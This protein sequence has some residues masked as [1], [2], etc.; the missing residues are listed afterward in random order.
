M[1]VLIVTAVGLLF[2]AG[3]LLLFRYQCQLRIDRQHELEKV[4]AVRSALNYM[5]SE[6]VTDTGQEFVYRNENSGRDLRL[7]VYPSK[8]FFPLTN[9]VQHVKDMEARHFVMDWGDFD[10][11]NADRQNQYDSRLD[12]GYGAVGVEVD[13]LTNTIKGI[14]GSTRGLI[15]DSR[16]ATND[17]VRCWVNI[18]MRKTGGWL[19]EEY[20]RRYAFYPKRVGPNDVVRLWLIRAPEGA[21]DAS[22]GCGFGWP[23]PSD[24]HPLMFE[25]KNRKDMS[26]YE[27]DGD[28]PRNKPLC[29]AS[30]VGEMNFGIQLAHDKASVFYIE[31]KASDA[32]ADDPFLRGYT[33]SSVATMSESTYKYFSDGSERNDEG[34]IISAPDMRVVFEV[35]L[36]RGGENVELQHFKVTPGYQYEV[37][38]EHPKGVINRATVAQRMG[39][40]ARGKVTLYSIMTYDTHGTEN[41]GFRKDEREAGRKRNRR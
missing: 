17:G 6:T 20:G 4:Y 28:H 39:Q 8:A 18:G 41:K 22:N 31:N 29:S 23:P 7:F 27:C 40:Y 33:F 12:Y 37:S 16:F 21:S 35:M 15:F 14:D 30:Y 38:L 1:T 2:G 13:D 34:K 9:D 10:I 36:E 32:D 5:K 26:L 25:F 19:Q 3:A 24:A 11:N